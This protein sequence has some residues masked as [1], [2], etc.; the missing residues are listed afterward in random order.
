MMEKTKISS[1]VISNMLD[2]LHLRLL[3]LPEQDKLEFFA[4]L[5]LLLEQGP[6]VPIERFKLLK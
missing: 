3:L 4:S 6:K 5:E 1:I 2:T